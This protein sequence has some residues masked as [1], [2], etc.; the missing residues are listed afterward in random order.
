MKISPCCCPENLLLSQRLHFVDNHLAQIQLTL[1]QQVKFEMREYVL[2]SAGARDLDIRGYELSDLED[3]EATWESHHLEI[4]CVFKP[5]IDIPFSPTEFDDL[6]MTG[7]S[8]NPNE[9]KEEE[10]K[11]NSSNNSI[12]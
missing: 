6:E 12:A 3:N 5:G 9:L 1:D 7:S 2:S 4:D 10:N 11:E 8:K